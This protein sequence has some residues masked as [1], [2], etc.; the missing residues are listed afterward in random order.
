[1]HALSVGSEAARM[2]VDFSRDLEQ[3]YLEVSNWRYLRSS[4]ISAG[5]FRLK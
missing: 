5:L 4:P 1:M 2:G 3:E